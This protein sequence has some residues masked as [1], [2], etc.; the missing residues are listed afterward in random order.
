MSTY[1]CFNIPQQGNLNPMLA[2]VQGLVTRGERAIFYLTEELRPSIE[3][4]GATFRSYTSQLRFDQSRPT[5]NAGCGLNGANFLQ[6]GELLLKDCRQLLPMVLQDI[7]GQRPDGIIYGQSAPWGRMLAQILHVPGILIRPTYAT[8]EHFQLFPGAI[9]LA[10][11]PAETE[12]IAQRTAIL[13]AQVRQLC[14]NYAIEPFDFSQLF[15]FAEPLTLVMLPRAFQ[16]A[17]ETFDSRFQFVG[18]CILPRHDTT[19]FPLDRLRNQLTLY[20]SLGTAFNDRPDFYNEC[21]RAFSDFPLQVVQSIGKRVQF[22]KLDPIPDNFIVHSFVPQLEVLAHTSIFI[23]HG[24]MNSTMEALSYG[25]PLIVIPQMLEQE[26]T[27]RRVEELGL[28]IALNPKNINAQ[29]L[30]DAV[31]TVAH[32]PDI[33]IHVRQMQHTIANAGGVHAAVD[34]ILQH[35]HTHQTAKT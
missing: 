15:T 2:I 4:T 32:H 29:V 30:R 16:Y 1:L 25:V 14:T 12:A 8:N 11:S 34:L 5:P 26:F 33:R 23:T 10:T 3:E 35:M 9:S 24:G 18:P 22:E 31:N 17:G 27:A 7:Q 13:N 19:N 20:I 21:F 6:F 28:G